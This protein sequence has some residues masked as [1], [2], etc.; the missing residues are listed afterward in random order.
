MKGYFI[1]LDYATGGVYVYPCDLDE[2]EDNEVAFIED[3][4]HRFS[5]CHF[6]TTSELILH[7]GE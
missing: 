7:I 3:K 6:M 2:V 5:D 1:I 4:G